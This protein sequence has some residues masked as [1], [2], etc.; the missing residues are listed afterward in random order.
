MDY[1]AAIDEII[2]FLVDNRVLIDSH[3]TAVYIVDYFSSVPLD[4]YE[5]LSTFTYLELL[6]IMSA[7]D[8]VY[9]I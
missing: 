7:I 2:P 9:Y 4:W 8:T 3:V 1:Q 6:Q 5:Y